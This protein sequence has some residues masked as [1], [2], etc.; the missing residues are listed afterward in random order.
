MNRHPL[1]GRRIMLSAFQSDGRI[2]QIALA[3]NRKARPMTNL[4]II[5]LTRQLGISP[6]VAEVLATLIFGGNRDE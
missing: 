4:R 1:G 6:H 3:R 2:P 5:R